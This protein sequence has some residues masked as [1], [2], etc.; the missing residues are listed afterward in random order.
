MYSQNYLRS[1]KNREQTLERSGGN[2]GKEPV[3]RFRDIKENLQLKLIMLSFLLVLCSYS[4]CYGKLYDSKKL[5]LQEK[6]TPSQVEEK[7]NWMVWSLGDGFEEMIFFGKNETVIA[8]RITQHIKTPYETFL[9]KK[10]VKS[11]LEKHFGKYELKAIPKGVEITRYGVTC[12]ITN[13]NE[14]WFD[15]KGSNELIVI[16]TED[17]TDLFITGPEFLQHIYHYIEDDTKTEPRLQ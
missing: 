1:G 15:V 9:E 13:E 12:F 4:N 14:Y 7:E 11:F 8:A 3:V 2:F 5:T 6:G 17:F 16:T 10:Q